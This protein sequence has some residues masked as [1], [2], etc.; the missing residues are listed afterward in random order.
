MASQPQVSLKRRG[1]RVVGLTVLQSRSEVEKERIVGDKVAR[2][3]KDE[4]GEEP[5]DNVRR[6]QGETTRSRTV[7]KSSHY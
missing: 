4:M 7:E 3:V 1:K 5:P 6:K 2:G